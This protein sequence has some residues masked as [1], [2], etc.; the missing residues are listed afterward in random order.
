MATSLYNNL[1][2]LNRNKNLVFTHSTND[3][4]NRLIEMFTLSFE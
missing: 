2:Q 4:I 3:N 1:P